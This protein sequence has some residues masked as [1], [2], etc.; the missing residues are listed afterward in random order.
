M[1]SL[2]SHQLHMVLSEHLPRPGIQTPDL[3]ALSP[4]VLFIRPPSVDSCTTAWF[5]GGLQ[6]LPELCHRPFTQSNQSE[7]SIMQSESIIMQVCTCMRAG[8]DMCIF[9]AKI[10]QNDTFV[11]TVSWFDGSRLYSSI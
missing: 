11:V 5:S 7:S 3:A 1:G 9:A 10:I 4:K 2:P 8:N 6:A